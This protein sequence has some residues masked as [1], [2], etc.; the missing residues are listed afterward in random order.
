MKKLLIVIAAF[1]VS[2]GVF[3]QDKMDKNT[4]EKT[5]PQMKHKMDMKK[6]YVMMKDGKMEMM[7]NGKTMPMDKEMTMGNGTTVM[8]DG[9]YKMKNGKTMQMK[10]GDMMYMNG[11]MSKMPKTKMDKMKM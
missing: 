6:D 8:T 3:A 11:K 9:M 7:K 4:D 2:S 10:D 5:H 1:T